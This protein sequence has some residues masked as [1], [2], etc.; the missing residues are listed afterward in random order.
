MYIIKITNAMR[1]LRL[2]RNDLSITES[3]ICSLYLSSFSC[4]LY[5]KLNKSF[6]S[7]TVH[8][9]DR[10]SSLTIND[11]VRPDLVQGSTMGLYIYYVYYA[12][13]VLNLLT[14]YTF[15]ASI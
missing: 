3:M 10:H 13:A 8:S 14:L 11:N 6:I 7:F 15:T 4:Y 2:A 5:L 12:H 9:R 1:T